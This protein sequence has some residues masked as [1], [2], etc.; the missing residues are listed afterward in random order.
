[1]AESC[2]RRW[3]LAAETAW[4]GCGRIACSSGRNG[5]SEPSIASMDSARGQV[6]H[7]EQVPGVGDREQQHAEHAVGTVDERQPLLGG[8]LDRAQ[9]GRGQGRGARPAGTVLAQHPALAEQHQRAVRQRRQVA[10]RAERSVLGY[11]W[12]DVVVEQVHKALGDQR[13]YAGPAQRQR[14]DPQQHHRPDHL[15][16]HRRADP[17]G[18]RA[19]QRVLQFGP[20]LGRDEGA[21]ERAETGGDAVD[22]AAAAL[23]VVHDGPAW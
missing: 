4:P 14:P 23:D 21:G 5:R 8:E 22:R 17:G 10:G 16:R 18:V 19:D 6:G 2:S 3:M 15:A 7:R 9:S 20:A 13:A 11:P 12:G 1:M